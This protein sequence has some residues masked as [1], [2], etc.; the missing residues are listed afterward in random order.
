MINH[1][2]RLHKNIYQTKI[3]KQVSKQAKKEINKS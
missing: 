2:N 3:S 1:L